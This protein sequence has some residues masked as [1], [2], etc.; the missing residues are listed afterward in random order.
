MKVLDLDLDFFLTDCCPLAPRGKRPC[1]SYAKTWSESDVTSYLEDNL[2]LSTDHPVLGVITETHDGAL[3]FWKH[4]MQNGCLK[5]PFSVV[6]IDAHSDLGIGY[7]GPDFVLN[8]VLGIPP[9]RRDDLQNYYAQKQLDE[10]NYLLFALAFR[11][12]DSLTLV[13][14][15][16]S[17]PDFPPFIVQ[18]EGIF[19]PIKLNSFISHLFEHAYGTEPEVPLSVYF[20]PNLYHADE[21]FTCMN[22]ACS[23]RYTPK[24]ADQL[25]P[26]I[27]RYMHLVSEPDLCYT[28][29]K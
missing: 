2:G 11:W 21:R 23:P 15:S 3:R 20:D 1:S 25:I 28:V 26:V 29:A 14:D 17:R 9:E 24:E 10:A 6:H 13:R 7:P 18:N 12:I 27:A 5:K 19:K 4:A 16:F 8:N 22:I